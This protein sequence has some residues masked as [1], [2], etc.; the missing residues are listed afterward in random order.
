MTWKEDFMKYRREKAAQTL[1]DARYLFEGKR[2]FSAVNQ[3]YYAL[4]YEVSA[5][6]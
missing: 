3:I 4:F 1:E 6:L 2:L 5:L